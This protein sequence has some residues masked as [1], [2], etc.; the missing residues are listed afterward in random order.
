MEFVRATAM[1]NPR[2]SASG[3]AV[4]VMIFVRVNASERARLLSML[5]DEQVLEI[6][7]VKS[8]KTGGSMSDKPGIYTIN[9]V[10]VP[11]QQITSVESFAQ[12][13]YTKLN[14]KLQD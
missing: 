13:V 1:P 11:R 12:E 14:T 9:L 2:K 3:S 5:G 4:I 10:A 7:G 8:L 6:L